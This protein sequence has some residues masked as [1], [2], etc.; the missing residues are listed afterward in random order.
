MS[1]YVLQGRSGQEE[2]IIHSC[3][4]HLSAE[5]LDSAF[6]FRCERLWRSEGE[7]KLTQKEMFPGYVFLESSRPDLL[8]IELERYRTIFKVMEEPGYLIS[9][10]QEEEHYL[11][12]LCGE[13]HL[14]KLSYGYKDREDGISH[15]TEGPLMGLEQRVA[16][17]DWHRRFAQV[18]VPLA[19]R[20]LIVWAGLGIAEQVL[21]REK[22]KPEA[23]FLVS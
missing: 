22:E 13:K 21:T 23:L 4:Q 3:R 5:A 15:I 16:R 2:K 18:E 1:W 14:L 10:Y 11:R 6:L 7:W 9:V 17:F 20:K 19:R 8:S 12:R